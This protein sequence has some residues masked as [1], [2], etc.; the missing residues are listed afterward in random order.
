MAIFLESHHIFW[1]SKCLRSVKTRRLIV[2]ARKSSSS[3]DVLLS[4]PLLVLCSLLGY[5]HH[6]HSIF[7]EIRKQSENRP[8]SPIFLLRKS[9]QRR[10]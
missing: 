10:A 8:C 9:H 6:L 5:F 2:L 3:V 7:L 4:A 1:A